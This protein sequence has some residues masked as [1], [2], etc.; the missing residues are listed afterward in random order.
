M[1]RSWG[2]RG[3]LL[4]EEWFAVV[5]VVAVVVVAVGGVATYTAYVSPGTTTEQRQVSSWAANGTY[6]LSA[7][8]S[9][10]NPLYPVGTELADR[11]AYFLSISPSAE[12]RFAF[13]YEASDGGSV[14][15]TIQQVLV[16]RAV[17][18]E[19]A[20]GPVEY[21]R[22]TEPLG[23]ESETGVA[24]G[25]TVDIAFERNVSATYERMAAI[26]ER[27][28]GT[29]G[30]TEMLVVSSV[31]FEGRV[32]GND[33]DRTATYR[34]PI[35]V[36]GT[37][38][39][40]G[41]V[42][43]DSLSDS[44][45]ETITRQRTYGPLYRVGGPVALLVGLLGTAG[46]AY[47]RYDDRLAVSEAERTT[48]EFESTREEFDDWIT[49]ARLPDAVL[50]R[51]RVEVD[52]LDGLV[53]TAIDV[54]ARVFEAPD[55]DAFYVADDGLLY[56]YEPPTAGLNGTVGDTEGAGDDAADTDDGP[57]DA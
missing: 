19:S 22:V 13:G 1:S 4:L 41:A 34:L 33:V 44:T 9:E 15:V 39:R 49:V 43:G 42:D 32:N 54:D 50:D 5:V 52:S 16:L 57:A 2:V 51:P 18:S 6:E 55:G 46:L 29:P 27:L 35:E 21:W 47:G 28:G 31:A 45:T 48:L 23:A 53:D 14:D 26:S 24:P 37:T 25:E 17:E 3:R 20:G 38:Y 11:P 36:D 12:G 30:T 40:P 10:P 8:V 7:T 56:V